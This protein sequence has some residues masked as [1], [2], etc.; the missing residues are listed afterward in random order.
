VLDQPGVSVSLR[1][2]EQTQRR[3]QEQQRADRERFA[4]KMRGFRAAARALH[5]SRLLPRG[6][7]RVNFAFRARQKNLTRNASAHCGSGKQRAPPEGDGAGT[8][9]LSLD[10]WRF[11]LP[12][13]DT[14]IC[15]A[16][17]GVFTTGM[18]ISLPENAV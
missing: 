1:W 13:A 3:E 10:F 12:D 7:A 18:Q 14:V 15:L 17:H 11:T 4:E 8:A 2:R 5:G 16:T 9:H 6:R